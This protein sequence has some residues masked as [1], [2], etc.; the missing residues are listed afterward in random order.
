MGQ[1]INC[2]ATF[3]GQSGQGKAHLDT[4]HLLFRGEFRVKLPF[5]EMRRVVAED[6]RLVIDVPD[7]RAT[8]EMGAQ[9]AKWAHK[10]LNPP[11]LLDKLGVKP[12]MRV[13]VLGI[14]DSEF[15][16]LLCASNAYVTIGSPAPD[17]DLLIVQMDETAD[18]ADLPD[19]QRHIKP[20]GGIWAVYPKGVK[21][22]TEAGVMAAAKAAG[23]VDVKTCAF[24][25]THTGLKLVI[26][27]DRR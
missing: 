2:A 24:S 15:T 5:K 9:A 14:E 26:P 6:D 7:G 23:L 12:G 19:L 27:V 20:N 18:L 10:I 1:E 17:S 8:F 3:N 21:R 22:I 13:S 4:D 25:A 11:T 16:G